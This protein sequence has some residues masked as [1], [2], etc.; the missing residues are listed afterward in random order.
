MFGEEQKSVNKARN[1]SSLPLSIEEAKNAG[2]VSLLETLGK[3][4]GG[5]ALGK[6]SQ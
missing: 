3:I 2:L 5:D 4:E 1:S 6:L